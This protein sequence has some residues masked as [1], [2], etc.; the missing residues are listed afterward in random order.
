ME[1]EKKE[2]MTILQKIDNWIAFLKT[3]DKDLN[4]YDFMI[5]ENI[6]K[7]GATGYTKECKHQN[8]THKYPPNRE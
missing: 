8:C 5:E 1:E 7:I 3:R 2:E 4:E 6:K